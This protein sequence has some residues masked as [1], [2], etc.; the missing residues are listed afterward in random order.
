MSLTMDVPHTS[1]PI[2]DLGAQV[3]QLHDQMMEAIEGVLASQSFILGPNVQAVEREIAEYCGV[4][5]A[6]GVASGTDALILALRSAG[7]GPGDEVIVPAFSFIATADAVSLLGARPV[8]AD[9]EPGTLNLDVASA[10]ARVSEK[11]KAI[12]PVHLYGQP[13]A[14]QEVLA[15]A[16]DHNLAVV[17]DCAQAL[18]ATYGAR[19]VAGLG[20]YG[21]ISFFPSK[22]LGAFGDGGMIVTNDSDAA[23]HLRRLRSH[24]SKRKYHSE[25]QGWNSRLDELQAAILRVKLPY[26]DLWNAARRKNADTYDALLGTVEGVQVLHR[27]GGGEPVFHQY[28]IRVQHRDAVQQ[29]LSRAGVQTCVYYP[30]PLHLQPMYRDLGYRPGDLPHAE[31]AAA[32]VLS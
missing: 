21:C 32:E 12:V 8:F 7:V 14:M 4:K 13:A 16:G 30:I 5:H 10:R 29:A 1:I 31:R 18:G 17:E 19:K 6:V 11:T 27:S 23:D 9:V 2:L 25:E 15:L 20:D 26:L 3:R 24:G 22:N 28:T